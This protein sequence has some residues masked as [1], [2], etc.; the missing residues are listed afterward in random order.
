MNIREARKSWSIER[1]KDR[2]A[3]L[4]KDTNYIVWSAESF[5]GVLHAVRKRTE[6]IEKGKKR[7]EI[8][9]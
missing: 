7:R 4:I 2:W 8:H 1:Y 3:V 6:L 9:R 5:I